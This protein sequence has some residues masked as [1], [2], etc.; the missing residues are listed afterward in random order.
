[1]KRFTV[2]LL[3][4]L[5]ALAGF[6]KP[7]ALAGESPGPA[8]AQRFMVAAANPH[9][10]RA[11]T[12]ML[13]AGG[14]A[15]DAAIAVQLVLNLVEPQSSGIGGGAFL[16]HWDADAHRLFAY[17]GRETA[18]SAATPDLFLD[19]GG[20]P[21]D[22]SD[23]VVGGRSVGAPGLLRML[24][25]AHRRHGTLPWA[26]LFEPAIE[27]AETGFRVSRRLHELISKDRFLGRHGPARE[28]FF[29]HDGRPLAEGELLR[30]PEFAGTLRLIAKGGADA[31]YTGPLAGRI[32]AAVRGF[33]A[34]PGVL[35]LADLE[36]YRA[37]ERQPICRRYRKWRV[38]GMPPP[39]SGGVTV[40]QILGLLER[41][42]L[43]AT[44]EVERV[45][46]F[47]EAGKLA[48]AD[49]ALYL[50]DADFVAVPVEGL[51]DPTYLSRR[52]QL[53][54]PAH[55]RG[56]AEPGDPGAKSGLDWSPADALELPSTSHISIVDAAGNAVSMTTS[57][58]SAF[59]SRLM[60]GG[61]LLNNQLTDF[62]F[63]PE[64]DGK[65]VANRVEPRKRPRSS[66]APVAVFEPNPEGDRL[67]LI[68]GSPGGSRII[69]YVAQTLIHVLDLGMDVR[70]AIAAPHAVNR[71]GVTELEAGTEVLELKEE[72]ERRGHEVVVRELNSGLH[73]IE[74]TAPG[75]EGAADPRREGV[76]VGE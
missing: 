45:H 22:F 69:A 52:S 70:T 32:V 27:L 8:A 56:R 16:L 26:R 48:Y 47:A 49:R 72:L 54:D 30:N 63:L 3:V 59:G 51:L 68:A 13:A 41:F 40:L 7:R 73:A 43:G 34:N 58:E 76:A 66:M 4:A 24:E 57:V 36:A 75:L 65:A 5:A 61:F 19:A 2:S 60:V 35:S 33:P 64:R 15:V 38:C 1:M 29:H 10:A 21:M 6:H 62:S 44:A 11:G 53:I 37:R 46:L 55:A 71:N 17:D 9:A 42:D 20:D 67:R 28:Y 23:A 31:F 50:A 25:L 74:L 14:S 39:T 18:P 12:R